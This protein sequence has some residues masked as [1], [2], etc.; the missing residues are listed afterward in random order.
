MKNVF[1]NNGF[2]KAQKSMLLSPLNYA[3]NKIYTTKSAQRAPKR[4]RV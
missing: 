1:Y 2:S 3:Q 4:I